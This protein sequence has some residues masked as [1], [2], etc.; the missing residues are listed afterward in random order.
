MG[1]QLFSSSIKWDLLKAF[2]PLKTGE[3]SP[4]CS[5]KC[6]WSVLGI[7]FRANKVPLL[8]NE[9]LNDFLTFKVHFGVLIRD[10]Q[11]I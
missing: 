8:Y 6:Q 10:I 4:I 2:A 1:V 9:F 11:N 7:Y 3:E 5:K